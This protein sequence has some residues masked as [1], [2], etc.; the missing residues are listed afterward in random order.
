MPIGGAFD[1]FTRYAGAA[2][3]GAASARATRTSIM[4]SGSSPTRWL[5]SSQ[6][7]RTS[8]SLNRSAR[9]VDVARR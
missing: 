3:S 1:P 5:I 6:A 9:T 2:S 8:P 7:Q 4:S